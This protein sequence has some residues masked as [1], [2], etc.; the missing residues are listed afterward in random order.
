MSR[1]SR[2]RGT[3]S[4]PPQPRTT[5]AALASIAAASPFGGGTPPRAVVAI[6]AGAGCD[7]AGI[8]RSLAAL[9][10]QREAAACGGSRLAPGVFGVVLLAAAPSAEAASL[11]AARALAHGLP[12]PLVVRAL[13]PPAAAV[14]GAAPAMAGWARR[15]A[16]DDAAEWL[17]RAGHAEDG[18][19]LTTEAGVRVAPDWLAANLAA[20]DRGA[21][22]VAGRCCADAAAAPAAGS[23]ALRYAARLDALAAALD[24]DPHDP[25][26]R[27]AAASGA[28]LALT[29]AAWRGVGGLPP[30][31]AAVPALLAALR[32]RDARLRHAPEVMVEASGVVV[33]SPPPPARAE[34]LADALRRLRL[35]A[36]LRRLW[37]AGD[38]VAGP[39]SAALHRAARALRLPAGELARRLDAPYFGAAW[40]AL[41]ATSATLE[42]RPLAPDALGRE[43]AK[44]AA[45]LPFIRLRARRGA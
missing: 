38:G 2:I 26:P 24:P 20:L 43:A 33:A 1:E 9:A 28:S 14:V 7:A 11:S 40:E 22:V 32:Q 34:A 37:A 10:A 29:L 6:A 18:V 35:R 31:E 13:H 8:A 45:L 16:L 5:A 25:W 41:E 39:E 15:W 36:T 17:E 21:D 23:P 44:A 30:R 19:L 42:F 4:P 3:P 27:H 12:F